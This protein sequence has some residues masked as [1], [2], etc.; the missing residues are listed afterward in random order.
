MANAPITPNAVVS[1][2]LVGAFDVGLGHCVQLPPFRL[3]R[4]LADQICDVACDLLLE[5]TKGLHRERRGAYA[6][7]LLVGLRDDSL[8]FTMP[9]VIVSHGTRP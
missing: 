8:Q 1:A 5:G 9:A 7:K 2:T 4:R 3:A 6:P